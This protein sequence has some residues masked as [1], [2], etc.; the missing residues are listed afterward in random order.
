[1]CH[2]QYETLV[3]DEAEM[4]NDRDRDYVHIPFELR[5]VEA[6]LDVVSVLKLPHALAVYSTLLENFT[7][8]SS[9][10]YACLHAPGLAVQPPP[11]CLRLSD[12]PCT[13][14]SE[15]LAEWPIAAL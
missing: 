9:G 1:M 11:T 3:N 12:L 15:S 7:I 4:F 13:L 10:H 14:V 8:I 6:A 5:V 2:A